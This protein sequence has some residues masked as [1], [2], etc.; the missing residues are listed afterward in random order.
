MKASNLIQDQVLERKFKFKQ[1]E[2]V[3]YYP[4]VNNRYLKYQINFCNNGNIIKY[5][6]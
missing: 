3:K 1:I 5:R 4:Y 2:K 6:F